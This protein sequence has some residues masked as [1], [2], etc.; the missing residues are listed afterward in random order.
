MLSWLLSGLGG[1][2]KIVLRR[3][4]LILLV[5]ASA[6]RRQTSW[7]QQRSGPD[8]RVASFKNTGCHSFQAKSL[9][10]SRRPVRKT[11]A[12]TRIS[13]LTNV[14]NSMVNNPRFCVACFSFP[15]P[16]GSARLSASHALRFQASD[17]INM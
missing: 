13:E 12:G 9:M 17:V 11:C 5:P 10:T 4:D 7:R 15:N 6:V 14:R 2:G 1:C 8:N 3:D 16:H